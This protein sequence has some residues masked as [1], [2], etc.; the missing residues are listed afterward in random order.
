MFKGVKALFFF[1]KALTRIAAALEEANRIKKFELLEMHQ[2]LVS[3]PKQKFSKFDRE[4]E[5]I[6]G[7]Q[8]VKEEDEW[9]PQ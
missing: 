5:V 4:A 6:Y 3:D 7:E 1:A 8:P 9:T 2:L